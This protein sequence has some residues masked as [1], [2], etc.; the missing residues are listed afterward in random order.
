VVERKSALNPGKNGGVKSGE[1][2]SKKVKKRRENEQKAEKLKKKSQNDSF[3]CVFSYKIAHPIQMPRSMLKWVRFCG[4]K[5]R[6][7][8]KA[9]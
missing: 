7:Q 1:K 5:F 8:N 4:A 6:S 9:D 2:K 3:Y